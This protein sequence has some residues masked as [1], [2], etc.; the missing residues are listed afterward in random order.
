MECTVILAG[1]WT[2][3][4]SHFCDAD[5]L[6]F[7]TRDSPYV[8]V[9][10]SSISCKGEAKIGHNGLSRGVLQVKGAYRDLLYH[11]N[12]KEFDYILIME[13]LFGPKCVTGFPSK[14]EGDL[15]FE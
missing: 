15:R 7:A 8:L 14:D 2:P 1:Y 6:A 11:R 12:S 9:A 13:L 10:N 5:T 3:C 4:E